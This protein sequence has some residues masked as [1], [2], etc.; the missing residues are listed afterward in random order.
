[1]AS[2]DASRSRDH[3]TRRLAALVEVNTCPDTVVV[4]SRISSTKGKAPKRPQVKRDG[5]K[6]PP[7]ASSVG[8]GRPCRALDATAR[9]VPIREL[10]LGRCGCGCG[11]ELNTFYFGFVVICVY[12]EKFFH[13]SLGSTNSIFHSGTIEWTTLDRFGQ[14]T[15]WRHSFE[16]R[17]G[18]SLHPIMPC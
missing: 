9:V 4:T 16:R 18:T 14:A 6:N 8:A 5:L 13:R 10:R 2:G 11:C 3:E 17:N 12:I 7:G 15:K 1:M